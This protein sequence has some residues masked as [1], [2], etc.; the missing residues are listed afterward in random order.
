MIAGLD[1]LRF[2]HWQ[3]ELRPDGVLVLS[4]DRAGE[5]VNTF[6]QDVLLELQRQH[7]R[8]I[9]FVSHDIEEA[10]RIGTRI[11]IMEG[12]RLIQVGTPQELIDNPVNDYVRNFFDAV[13]TSRYL[14]AGQLTSDDVPM[15][16]HNGKAPRASTVCRT[17]EE[18]NKAFGIVIDEDN[19]LRGVI[20][21]E[22]AA[23]LVQEDQGARVH[24][25]SLESVDPMPADASL[26]QVIERL[27]ES[28]GPVPVVD[29]DGN[30][31][32][33]ISKTAVLTQLKGGQA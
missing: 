4:F 18:Q 32:G 28:P 12:G 20:S 21:R 6:A 31:C 7:R 2:S 15:F 27:V 25:E 9:L 1:G 17:L 29:E 11:G 24:S 33:A 5:S 8:T 16:V 26:E 30:Y 23:Q 13:D 10:L 14:T 3:V 19:T 22:Q